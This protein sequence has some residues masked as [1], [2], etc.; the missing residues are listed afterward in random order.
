MLVSSVDIIK[1]FLTKKTSFCFKTSFKANIHCSAKRDRSTINIDAGLVALNGP[2][3]VFLDDNFFMS[4][5]R[6]RF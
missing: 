2:L 3:N 5:T 1:R 6:S 4:P